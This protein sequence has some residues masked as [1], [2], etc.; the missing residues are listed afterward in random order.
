MKFRKKLLSTIVALAMMASLVTAMPISVGATGIFDDAW[1]EVETPGTNSHETTYRYTEPTISGGAM[2]LTSND[3]AMLILSKIPNIG[4]TWDST[5]TYT[6]EFD[7]VATTTNDGTGG[8][9]RTLFVAP[10]GWY[11]QVELCKTQL[12]AG[13]SWDYSITT[14]N[15][16]FHYR[17]DLLNNRVTTTITDNNNSG[18]LVLSGFRTNDD[19][20]RFWNYCFRCENGA[21][22]VDNVKV[23]KNNTVLLEENF[24]VFRAVSYSITDADDN[25]IADPLGLDKF[26]IMLTYDMGAKEDNGISVY[27]AVYGSDGRLCAV[28]QGVVNNGITEIEIELAEPYSAGNYCKVFTWDTAMTPLLPVIYPTQTISLYPVSDGVSL[29]NDLMLS[30]LNDSYE[31]A[32]EYALGTTDKD[33]PE[34]VIFVWVPNGDYQEYILE[35]SESSDMSDAVTINTDK[36]YY[37]LY[38]LKVGT[39]YY[40]R[41]SVNDYTSEISTFTTTD[42]APRFIQVSGLGNARDVGGWSTVDGKKVKQ[43][44]VYRSMALDSTNGS[45]YVTSDGI[46]TLVNE[47]GIK[48]EID[49]RSES[50][51]T[52]SILGNGVNYYL[53]GM[54]TDYGNLY[55]S[56]QASIK[57][58]FDTLADSSNYPIILHCAGGADRTGL[59]TYLLNGLLGVS[60]EDLLRD[61]LFTNFA[62]VGSKRT[63]NDIANKYVKGLDEYEGTSLSDKIYNYLNTEVGVSTQNLDFIKNYMTE[64]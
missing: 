45:A 54:N 2:K 46:D 11:N 16:N 1:W 15:R 36:T 9:N 55:N 17:L 12:R 59:I 51:K 42:K 38:N 31:N 50:V 48:S 64:N 25:V 14:K 35:V 37:G 18:A 6:I 13:D 44:L 39:R 60:K 21:V 19:Y 27:A 34:P 57:K 43:G 58:V 24:E 5:A 53:F 32:T 29:H 4:A 3:S 62:S 10:D 20:K 8:G 33:D 28:K 63:L 40:W 49:L 30:Y 23:S 52:S 56:N 7:A 41:V 47:L 26:N 22:T 61:Y